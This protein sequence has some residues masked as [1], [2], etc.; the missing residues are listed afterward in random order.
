M[1]ILFGTTALF[2]I[3]FFS[4]RGISENFFEGKLK[5][6]LEKIKD[7]EIGLSASY[8]HT[9][10]YDKINLPLEQKVSISNCQATL[11][12]Y[13]LDGMLY[14]EEYDLTKNLIFPKKFKNTYGIAFGF[15]SITQAKP[16]LFF[17]SRNKRNRVMK[18]FKK[19]SYLC[20]RP[21][22]F[23][24]IKKFKKKIK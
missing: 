2:L 6:K 12:H 7:L 1:K 3:M 14:K 11:R 15:K 4:N 10:I 22:V 13:T 23:F 20:T 19:L 16:K 17:P 24:H 18:K 21:T 9:F 8:H 5:E